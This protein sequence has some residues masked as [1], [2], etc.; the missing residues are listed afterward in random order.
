MSCPTSLLEARQR[1]IGGAASLWFLEGGSWESSFPLLLLHSF[2]SLLVLCALPLSL[3]FRPTT[4]I[5][6]LSF[7]LPSLFAA[8]LGS[9]LAWNTLSLFRTTSTTTSTAFVNP[10]LG[11]EELVTLSFSLLLSLPYLLFFCFRRR[12]TWM[13]YVFATLLS[14]FGV[15]LSFS[16]LLYQQAGE[17][18][19]LL[20][21]NPTAP[22]LNALNIVCPLPCFQNGTTTPSQEACL[23]TYL[24]SFQFFALQICVAAQGLVCLHVLSTP[25]FS[26]SSLSWL[27]L[28]KKKERPNS[29]SSTRGGTFSATRSAGVTVDPLSRSKSEW[30]SMVE[31]ESDKGSASGSVGSSRFLD[32]A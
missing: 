10:F 20:S 3:T 30:S 5:Q 21:S 1:P 4:K 7:L 24:L 9:F 25:L 27:K 16:D 6:L 19:S 32:W 13:R 8:G 23:S 15:L 11:Y 12:R 17:E 14:L 22:N 18:A 28:S 26:L 31:M 2:P 29:R